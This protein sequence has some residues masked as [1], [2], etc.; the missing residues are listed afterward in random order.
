VARKLGKGLAYA[1]VALA[2]L[3]ALLIACANLPQVRALLTAQSNDALAVARSRSPGA[4]STCGGKHREP[5]PGTDLA[6]PL[7]TQRAEPSPRR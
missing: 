7:L 6:A 2:A 3:L 4:S 5:S 1:T